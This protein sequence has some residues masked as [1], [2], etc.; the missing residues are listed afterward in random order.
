MVMFTVETVLLMEE[1]IQ[2]EAANLKM[3]PSD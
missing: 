1:G 2:L 3:T